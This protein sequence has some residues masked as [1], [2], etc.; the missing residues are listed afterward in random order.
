MIWSLLKGSENKLNLTLVFLLGAGGT[1]CSVPEELN[2]IVELKGCQAPLLCRLKHTNAVIAEI[3]L[4][5]RSGCPFA[6]EVGGRF[7]HT[8]GSVCD[9]T[10]GCLG[11]ENALCV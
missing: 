8:F 6:V 3:Y 1:P 10:L 9:T 4:K 5:C 7:S 2:Q 11:L